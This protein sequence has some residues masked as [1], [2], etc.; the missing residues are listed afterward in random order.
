M[1]FWTTELVVNSKSVA[2]QYSNKLLL[3]DSIKFDFPQDRYNAR[4]DP[5][6]HE[7]KYF[8]SILTNAETSNSRIVN[9]T[10]LLIF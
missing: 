5:V 9:G 6:I 8:K 7:N 4:F 10:D 2:Q 1:C 3:W